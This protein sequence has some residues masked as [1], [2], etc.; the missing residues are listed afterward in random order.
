MTPRLALPLIVCALLP[1]HAAGQVPVRRVASADQPA[2]GTIGQNFA[3]IGVPSI[4]PMGRIMFPSGLNN[5]SPEGSTRGIWVYGPSGGARVFHD[6]TTQPQTPPGVRWTVFPTTVFGFDSA[7]RVFFDSLFTLN[8]AGGSSVVAFWVGPPE[9]VSLV[10]RHRDPAPGPPGTVFEVLGPPLSSEPKFATEAG[11]VAFCGSLAGPGVNTTNDDGVWATVAG[12]L[13]TIA[14]E[15]SPAPGVTPA[16]TF[17]NGFSR[18]RLAADG[19][20]V[21]SGTYLAGA[22]PGQAIYRSAPGGP[23]AAVAHTGEAA[24]GGNGATF[25]GFNLPA[26]APGGA[27]AAVA[28]LSDGRSGIWSGQ[29]LSFR[30]VTGQEPPGLPGQEFSGF[31]RPMLDDLGRTAF[32][33]SFRDAATGSHAGHGVWIEKTGSMELLFSTRMPLPPSLNAQGLASI[34]NFCLNNSGQI[35]FIGVLSG[36]GINS[37]NDDALLATDPNG[38]LVVVARE[39]GMLEYAPGAFAVARF[40]AMN[41]DELGGGRVGQ[42]LNDAGQLTFRAELFGIG[43]SIL[44][45]NVPPAGPL[46]LGLVCTVLLARRR[47]A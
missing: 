7:G 6:G 41:F 3:S 1:L 15:G 35:A 30:A 2:P 27:V 42:A 17:T 23:L 37:S 33:A 24:P 20:L 25:T 40:L 31:Q 38:S 47:R 5:S 44:V 12:T 45:A 8:G 32:R 9:N 39:G 34:G 19:G 28:G 11:G 16:A 13:A 10:V 14:R 43:D 36:P 4:D 29:T 46:S 22:T 18:P 26:I 21:F